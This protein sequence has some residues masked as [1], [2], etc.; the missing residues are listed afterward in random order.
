MTENNTLG[1]L[2]L[3]ENISDNY[4]IYGIVSLIVVLLLL[5]YFVKNNMIVNQYEGLQT[6]IM[7]HNYGSASRYSDTI[8]SDISPFDPITGNT[9]TSIVPANTTISNDTIPT[10]IS[11]DTIPTTISSSS[12]S[13]QSDTGASDDI[14]EQLKSAETV[15]LPFKLTDNN[16]KYGPLPKGLYGGVPTYLYDDF[17][18]ARTTKWRVPYHGVYVPNSKAYWK[19]S[20]LPIESNAWFVYEPEYKYPFYPKP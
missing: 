1:L 16:Y 20:N 19:A 18:N 5:W 11:N 12:S 7:P 4:S 10:T 8:L 2:I 13:S 17:D 15:D 3:T 9:P 6:N 14:M